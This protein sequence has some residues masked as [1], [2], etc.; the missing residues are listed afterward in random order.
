MGTRRLRRRLRRYDVIM[1]EGD[2][3]KSKN[4]ECLWCKGK[5]FYVKN[6]IYDGIYLDVYCTNKDCECRQVIKDE[7]L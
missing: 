4:Y 6:I 3:I 1:N 7:E 5:E 2:T